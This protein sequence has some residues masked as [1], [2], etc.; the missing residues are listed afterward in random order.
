MRI[1]IIVIA[2]LV[3]A[4]VGFEFFSRMVAREEKARFD[5][6]SPEE[7]RKYQEQMYKRQQ[8]A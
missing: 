5:K 4:G 3:L 2:V 7:R 1:L 6:M 8:L